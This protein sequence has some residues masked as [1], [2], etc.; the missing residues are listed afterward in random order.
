MS[1][2][3]QRTEC[4]L[5]TAN[6]ELHKLR[7]FQVSIDGKVLSSLI[8]NPILNLNPNIHSALH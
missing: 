3:L 5:Q 4:E 2:R 7:V 6:A 8:S 1:S